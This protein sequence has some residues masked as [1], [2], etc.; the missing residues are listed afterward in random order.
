MANTDTDQSVHHL[1]A[2]V[3]GAKV[4]CMLK[5][6]PIFMVNMQV[7]CAPCQGFVWEVWE[8]VWEAF[9][10]VSGHP[11]GGITRASMRFAPYSPSRVP[12]ALPSFTIPCLRPSHFPLPH[13]RRFTLLPCH[14]TPHPSP[15]WHASHG[16][17]RTIHTGCFSW[18][19]FVSYLTIAQMLAQS[20]CKEIPSIISSFNL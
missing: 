13:P 11:A 4:A 17:V 20:P 10:C 8:K 12:S 16:H 15:P 18:C 19:I 5:H 14:Q 2:V 9:A 7:R 6:G 3:S 1:A